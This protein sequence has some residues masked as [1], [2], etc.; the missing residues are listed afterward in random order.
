[1]NLLGTLVL[2]MAVDYV[3]G[4]AAAVFGRSRKSQSGGL[5]SHVG[6]K[7]LCRKGISLLVVLVACQLDLVAQTDFIGETVMIAY[8]VN[9]LISIVENAG[10]IGVPIPG[11]LVRVI[12]VLKRK[13]EENDSA[14]QESEMICL[15]GE[16]QMAVQSC[17]Q[18]E[19]EDAGRVEME[20]EAPEVFRCGKP[21]E[22]RKKNDDEREEWNNEQ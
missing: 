7:G 15:P 20:N 14:E 17:A 11:I 18:Q 12:G 22:N 5:E 9:E 19:K 2:F 13:E 16:A 6:W 4:F 10:L 21:N 1:M 8:L 3:T